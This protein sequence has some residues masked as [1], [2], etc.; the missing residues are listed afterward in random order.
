MQMGLKNVFFSLSRC[1]F[2]HLCVPN[3]VNETCA[4]S[5]LAPGSCTMEYKQMAICMLSVQCW[6]TWSKPVLPTPKAK[7]KYILDNVGVE[8]NKSGDEP[9]SQNL[10]STPGTP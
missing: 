10:V 9:E 5:R 3:F 8:Q 1:L 4:K 6:P 2:S 7:P